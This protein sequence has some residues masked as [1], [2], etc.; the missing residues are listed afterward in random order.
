MDAEGGVQVI[1]TV[2]AVAAD[3]PNTAMAPSTGVNPT[4]IAGIALIGLAILTAIRRFAPARE[5]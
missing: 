1:A 2:D 3:M 4:L 5:R